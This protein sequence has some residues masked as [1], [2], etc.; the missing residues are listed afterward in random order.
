VP[1]ETF[2]VSISEREDAMV[3]SAEDLFVV[4]IREDKKHNGIP[5]E[6]KLVSCRSQ[7]EAEM[8]RREN[9]TPRNRCI[10][11]YLGPAGGGD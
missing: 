3:A 11:R 1:G 8:V 7:E 4:Y 9:E 10:V 5:T 2:D 6:R